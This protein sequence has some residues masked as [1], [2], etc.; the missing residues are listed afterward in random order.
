MRKKWTILLIPGPSG[1]V[2]DV[3]F[4]ARL[5]MVALIALTAVALATAMYCAK[6]IRSWKE[7]NIGAISR[8][9]SDVAK[10]ERELGEIRTEYSKL[11]ELEEK[12][13]AIAGLK[14]REIAGAGVVGK[15]GQGGPEPDEELPSDTAELLA[16]EPPFA[17]STM[18]ADDFLE[19]LIA[20]QDSF[21]GI[22]QAFEREQR[23]LASVPSITPIASHD[24]WVSSGFA[25]RID[26]IDGKRRFH[27]GLDL[28]APRRTPIIAP[29][30]GVVTFSG[31][32]AGLGRTIEISHGYGYRTIYGHNEKLAKRTG[33]HV[34]RG[35]LIAFLGSTGRST[36]PHLHYEIHLSGKL[37]NP[38]RYLIE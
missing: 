11:L 19:A 10:R 22:L 20:T 9:E 7:N 25:Y 34:K 29:A 5:I 15:G 17:V 1:E 3:T 33:D 4:S 37:V 14:P 13:R 16:E 36:G 32:R 24:T 23:R 8:L 38:S 28:V 30:D 2:H 21:S 6:S 18:S 27:E 35:D 12:L 26:P 31:W